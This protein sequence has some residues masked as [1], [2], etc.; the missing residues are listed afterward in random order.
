[1]CA[2]SNVQSTLNTER[3]ADFEAA[4]ETVKFD[5]IG[6]VHIDTNT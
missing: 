4:E 3:A 2:S 1:M 5:A 6:V